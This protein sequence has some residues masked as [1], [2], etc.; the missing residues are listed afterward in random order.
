MF[1]LA[2]FFSKAKTMQIF[3]PSVMVY[4]IPLYKYYVAYIFLSLNLIKLTLFRSP[5][6]VHRSP[7]C[8]CA[9]V[10]FCFLCMYVCVHIYIYILFL[11][12]AHEHR[13]YICW[14]RVFRFRSRSCAPT[15]IC[16]AYQLSTMGWSCV[17]GTNRMIV[18]VNIK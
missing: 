10:S 2:L 9:F 12:S 5:L 6:S 3:E 7:F 18:N 8:V 13:T 11:Q 16:H 1:S 4:R 15:Q 17:S 14:L